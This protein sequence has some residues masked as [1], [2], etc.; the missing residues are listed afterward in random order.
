MTKSKSL[1][2]Y[3]TRVS[4]YGEL[5]QY[6]K[7]FGAAKLNFLIVC[8]DPGVGKSRHI[9]DAVG[10][11]ACLIEGNATPLGL[12]IKL[13]EHRHRPIVLDDV[14]DLYLDR[15]GRR[16]LKTL[17]QTEPVKTVS[18][19]ST[20]QVLEREGVPRQFTTRSRVALIA[21]QWKNLNADVAALEDRA[22][23]IHFEPAPLE[24]HRQAAK[25]FGDQEVFEFIGRHLHLMDSHSLRLYGHALE[26]KQAG[27]DWQKGILSRCLAGAALEVAR[28]KADPSY[29]SEEA[30]VQAFVKSKHGCRATYFNLG[31]K[32]AGPTTMP[33]IQLTTNAGPARV[34]LRSCRRAVGFPG[35]G[36]Y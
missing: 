35:F 12:F 6:A 16:L 27:L 34:R 19:Q 32:L 30:R 21:N 15:N 25:W 23:F 5:D 9:R 20:T 3:V 24:V 10:N 18:W 4:T 14:D 17:C 8:G 36:F 11:R 31:K 26:L 7:A 22:H 29:P 13:Y 2:D 1:P 28:L 33:M